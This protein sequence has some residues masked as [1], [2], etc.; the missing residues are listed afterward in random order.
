MTKKLTIIYSIIISIWISGCMLI[1]PV[2]A[3]KSRKSMYVTYFLGSAGIQYFIKPIALRG[4]SSSIFET[5]FTFKYLKNVK[6]SAVINFSIQH[7]KNIYKN[8][9][10]VYFKNSKIAIKIT[11]SKLL[12]NEKPSKYYTSRFSAKLTQKNLKMLFSSNDWEV[13]LDNI[14]FKPTGRTR[15]NIEYLNSHVFYLLD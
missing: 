10:T 11:N 14:T 2:V 12:Y 5:D 9:D 6:D 8:I 15:K 4:S 1:K 7:K 3:V 13:R